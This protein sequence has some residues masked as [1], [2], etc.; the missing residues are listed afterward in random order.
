MDFS[1]FRTIESDVP[2][3]HASPWATF[4][5]MGEYLNIVSVVEEK[6]L[7]RPPSQRGSLTDRKSEEQQAYEVVSGTIDRQL[8][9]EVHYTDRSEPQHDDLHSTDVLITTYE[10]LPGTNLSRSRPLLA[11]SCFLS[12]VRLPG[13]S[14]GLNISLSV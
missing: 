4:S 3:S 9:G 2:S 11:L 7:L 8:T 10:S 13:P 6:I 14:M 1:L 12:S 5:V